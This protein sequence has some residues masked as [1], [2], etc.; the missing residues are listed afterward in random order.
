MQLRFAKMHGL[1]NDFVVFDGVREPVGLTPERVQAVADRRYGV[2]CDQV[3]VISPSERSEVDFAYRVFNADGSEAEQC[4]NGVRCL[5]WFAY[6]TGLSRESHLVMEGHSGLIAL[7]LER[8][9]QV[10]AKM[11]VPHW[12]SEGPSQASFG[13]WLQGALE[14]ARARRITAVSMGNPHC[15]LSVPAVAETPVEELGPALES[16]PVFPNR[17]NVEFVE[18]TGPDRLRVR[19]W[20]RGVGLTGACGTGACASL[21]AARLWEEVGPRAVVELE[22][23]SLMVHWAGVGWPVYLT[24]PAVLIFEG[25]LTAWP[26]SREVATLQTWIKVGY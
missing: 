1:G 10:T 14:A 12:E 20:E 2:G 24:G 15:V 11:G 23:G 13:P 8:R 16:H 18:V 6:F 3:L 17:T 9:G 5:A 7:T 26:Q 4:G 21:V 25:F 19:V 22:G